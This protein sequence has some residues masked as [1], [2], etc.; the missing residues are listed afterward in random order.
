MII[1]N[2]IIPFGKKYVAIN[3]FGVIFAKTWLTKSMIRHEKIHTRQQMEM[4]YVG[5]FLWYVVEW[6][7]RLLYYRNFYKAYANISFER[8]AYHN[9]GDRSYLKHRKHYAWVKYITRH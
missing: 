2:R 5:F 7:M 3:L 6:G 4:L 1:N 9:Q 8:E